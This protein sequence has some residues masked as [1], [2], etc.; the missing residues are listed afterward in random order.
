MRGSHGRLVLSGNLRSGVRSALL[1]RHAFAVAKAAYLF[2]LGWMLFFIPPPP[3]AYAITLSDMYKASGVKYGEL[4]T[5]SGS[6]IQL[7]RPAIAVN[8]IAGLVVGLAAGYII[9]K[10]QEALHDLQI[11]AGASNSGGFPTP[12]G[13]NTPTD[14]GTRNA[15][16]A[17]TYAFTYGGLYFPGGYSTQAETGGYPSKEAAGAAEAGIAAQYASPTWG[18]VGDLCQGI[19]AATHMSGTH[20]S[21]LNAGQTSGTIT[22]DCASNL[23]GNISPSGPYTRNLA[24]FITLTRPGCAGL[25]DGWEYS[26]SD[27]KCHAVTP[28]AN[29]W[30]SDGVPTLRHTTGGEWQTMPYDPDSIGLQA[31][32]G[33]TLTFNGTTDDGDLI[34]NQVTANTDGSLDYKV[35]T[36]YDNG[37]GSSDVRVDQFTLSPTGAVTSYTHN[38]YGNTTINNITNNTG[39]NVVY[40]EPN[41]TVDIGSGTID[42]DLPDDYNRESTQQEIKDALTEQATAPENPDLPVVTPVL[43]EPV[44][45]GGGYTCPADITFNAMGRSMTYSWGPICNFAE[46]VNPVVVL[47]GIALGA[48]I[49]VGGLRT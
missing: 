13:W 7:A 1:G 34:Q 2:L 43:P 40:Q 17:T 41:P 9:E 44:E 22:F 10:G 3:P 27:G 6:V 20:Y 23:T 46:T 45:L 36:Q 47:A 48:F 42:I 5:R 38:V 8:P 30:D 49:L 25:G 39:G 28:P 35:T 32:A 24:T 37:S 16:N 33:N 14:P 12:T 4:I 21:G 29:Q 18:S 26:S 11:Q 31:P 19:T 15:S